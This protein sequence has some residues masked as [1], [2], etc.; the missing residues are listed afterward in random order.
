LVFAGAMG[1]AAQP[2]GK[3][4]LSIN[5]KEV[6][7]FENSTKRAE[8]TQVRDTTNFVGEPRLATLRWFPLW[9]SD[10]DASGVFVL[11]VPSELLQKGKP[12]EL[13]VQGD[14]TASLRWFA[15]DPHANAVSEAAKFQ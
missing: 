5:G 12:A 3:F 6:V 10:Q 7:R 2:E 1:F 15:I 11:S 13:S 8:W 4:I 14:A 9:N